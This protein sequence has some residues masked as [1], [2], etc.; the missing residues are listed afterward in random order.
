MGLLLLTLKGMLVG[1]LQYLLPP[2]LHSALWELNRYL[3]R[4]LLLH[5]LLH[6]LLHQREALQ[7]L[8][9]R[10]S[11]YCRRSSLAV[12]VLMS[13]LVREKDSMETGIIK[14]MPG[15]DLKC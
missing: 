12:K 7:T 13:G 3:S 15:F 1:K 8:L 11:R 2:D 14:V 5:S 4:H 6:L 9:R 10:W